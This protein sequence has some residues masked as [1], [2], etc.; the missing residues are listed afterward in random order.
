MYCAN[1]VNF[2][3]E[4]SFLPNLLDH[5]KVPLPEEC[6][7]GV[8]Q[9]WEMLLWR[10]SSWYCGEEVSVTSRELPLTQPLSL[11]FTSTMKGFAEVH[12]AS[13][14]QSEPKAWLPWPGEQEQSHRSPSGLWVIPKG[15]VEVPMVTIG[16]WNNH[17]VF[18]VDHVSFVLISCG[19]R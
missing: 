12:V 13:A 18:I 6:R 17:K 7:S 14:S 3:M 11:A 1:V 8:S 19:S 5:R 4:S 10:T 9:Q 16:K 2:S 15:S